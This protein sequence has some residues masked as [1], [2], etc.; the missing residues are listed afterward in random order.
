LSVAQESR[1]T[2]VVA[3]EEGCELLEKY[4]LADWL[5]I[6]NGFFFATKKTVS[7]SSRYLVR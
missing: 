1:G 2:V 7:S 6:L 5:G 4:L 3:V